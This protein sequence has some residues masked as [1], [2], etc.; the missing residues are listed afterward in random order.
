MNIQ[1]LGTIPPPKIPGTEA[2]F[3]EIE[4]LVAAFGGQFINLYPFRRYVPGY[5]RVLYGAHCIRELRSRDRAADLHHV[6]MHHLY[7]L[8]A[9]EVL[10]KPI[11]CEL[12]TPVNPRRRLPAGQSLHVV[13]NNRRDKGLLE[14]RGLEHVH[15]VPPG[16]DTS[17]IPDS[18]PPAGEEFVL[19]CGSAPWVPAHF[20]AKG[21]D[22]VLDA[23]RRTPGLRLVCLW[24]GVLYP[25]FIER[26]RRAGVAG[27]VEVVNRHAD[28]ASVLPRVHA[29]VLLA[30]SPGV[31]NAYPRS[32]IEALVAGKPVITSSIIPLA[33][34][35]REK[36]CGC[37]AEV[38]SSGDLLRC[39][40]AVRDGYDRLAQNA[41]MHARGD[42]SKEAMIEGYRR[43]YSRL[44]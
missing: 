43:V 27:R 14:A 30:E 39:V 40:E 26:V 20:R 1:Y 28:L 5:P 6:F 13:V 42:F 8:P 36:E 4:M 35:V 32:L 7:R 41:R 17:R 12:V 16:I 33:D 24:R 29:A 2:I 22:L 21:F 23:V 31:V 3:Q 38:F 34:Y 10:K 44:A 11:V 19:F 9:L 37:V 18:G 25:E 15:S